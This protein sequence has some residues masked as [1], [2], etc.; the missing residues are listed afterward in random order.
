VFEQ[1]SGNRFSDNSAT[2]GGDGFFLYAGNETLN[3]TGLGGCN[4]NMVEYNDFS[5]AVANG[6]EAT[7]S[8]G[9]YL[10]YNVLRDCEHGVW[11]GYSS[12]TD[13][14]H[15][16]IANCGSGVSIEHGHLNGLFRN[17]IRD[18]RVG[19]HLWR[20]A[21]P[22]LA[23]TPY[24]QHHDT[25]SHNNYIEGNEFDGNTTDVALEDDQSSNIAENK[26]TGAL[27]ITRSGDMGKPDSVGPKDHYSESAVVGIV[28][29]TR[30]PDDALRGRKYILVDDWGPIPPTETRL[31]PATI[32]AV[33]AAKLSALGVDKKFEVTSLTDGFVAEPM[34]GE[35]PATIVVRHSDPKAPDPFVV[36]TA[37]GSQTTGPKPFEITVRC[38]IDVR[39]ARGTVSSMPWD[40]RFFKDPREDAA[41]W[42]ALLAT[43][44][45]ETRR[46][47]GLDYAWNAGAVSDKVGA[48][49]FGT[50]ATSNVLVAA[51]KWRLSTVSDD[52]IRVWV[53]GRLVV[54]DWT[55]HGPTAHDVDVD[56][57]AGKHA[58]RVEHFQI[59]GWAAL[60]VTLA[61]VAK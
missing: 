15:N 42:K 51:G 41:A 11:A 25:R 26:S 54:D 61:P 8:D 37:P 2:H 46:V 34:T 5:H 17:V 44:P 14:V 50:L 39:T 20:D 57:A 31:F 28:S 52:G 6:I 32:D 56:L 40:V 10:S 4:N 53:D 3:R 24:W 47:D 35:M 36:R 9:N 27:V 33:G 43:E 49:R 19:V 18:C 22:A 23:K 45:V 55:Q 1:C 38:G 21:N 12:R 60:R 29:P 16:E 58:L 7:F 59:D 13:I 30:L 48:D